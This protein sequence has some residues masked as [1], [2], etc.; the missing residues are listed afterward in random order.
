MYCV[1]SFSNNIYLSTI[2][3]K[4][5]V[6][7]VISQT[8]SKPHL[9]N[10]DSLQFPPLFKKKLNKLWQYIQAIRHSNAKHPLPF[11][12]HQKILSSELYKQVLVQID[13]LPIQ[14]KINGANVYLRHGILRHSNSCL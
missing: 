6:W 2:N 5:K 9:F 14:Q 12:T 8:S 3:L 11:K 7:K 13:Q 1:R 4:V 10:F